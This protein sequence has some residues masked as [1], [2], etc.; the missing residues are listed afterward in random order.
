MVRF[1]FVLIFPAEMKIYPISCRGVQ[2]TTDDKQ[3]I[4]T[5]IRSL[6]KII[7]TIG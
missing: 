1:F 2:Y 4:T 6:T 7:Q 5:F 3:Q